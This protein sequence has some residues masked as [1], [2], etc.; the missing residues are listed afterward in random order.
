MKDLISKIK[1]FKIV[2]DKFKSSTSFNIKNFLDKDIEI[3]L[4]K[5]ADEEL[6]DY[7]VGADVEVFGSGK[8]GLMYFV[9]NITDKSKNILKIKYPE[10]YKDIQRREYSRVSFGGSIK[11]LDMPEV[12][13][14]SVDISAGG[15]KFL[16]TKEL[17]TN[18]A[19]NVILSL[20]N[21]LEIKCAVEPIRVK[22]HDEDGKEMYLVSG[23]FLNIES[24]DRIALIQYTFRILLESENKG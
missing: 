21:N 19:Y 12:E 24:V 14:K 22:K 11:F 4:L 5:L 23:K 16:S 18:Y 8:D 3:E 15:L 2:P 17:E 20:N 13:A 10:T 6:E 7:V 1:D 9:T